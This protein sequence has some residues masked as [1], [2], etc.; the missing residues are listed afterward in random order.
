MARESAPFLS[1]GDGSWSVNTDDDE[2]DEE[3][4]EEEEEEEEEEGGVHSACTRASNS[5]VCAPAAA[6]CP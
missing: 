2:A 3:E 6:S 1:A 4:A 5:R